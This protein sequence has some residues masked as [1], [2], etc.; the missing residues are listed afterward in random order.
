[1]SDIGGIGAVILPKI[2]DFRDAFDILTHYCNILTVEV[3]EDFLL[4]I[5]YPKE[6]ELTISF[7]VN[8][9]SEV[10]IDF[11]L[12]GAPDPETMRVS[13]KYGRVMELPLD[14]HINPDTHKEIYIKS[15]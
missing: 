5:T 15:L 6:G 2:Y 14:G 9:I 12:I 7:A 3:S 1:M 10:N 4:D 8:G 13:V 11:M